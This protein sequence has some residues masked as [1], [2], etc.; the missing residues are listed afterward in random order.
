MEI[1]LILYFTLGSPGLEDLKH[2][3]YKCISSCCLRYWLWL[4]YRRDQGAAT[5]S[6]FP[7]GC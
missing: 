3:A 4:D 1:I 6:S 7:F 5:E 2:I